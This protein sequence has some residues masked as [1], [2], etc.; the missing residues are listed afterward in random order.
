MRTADLVVLAA[1]FVTMVT[2]GVAYSR[3]KTSDMYFA[4]G[5][6]LSWW[7]GGVSFFMSNV[8]ALSIVVYAGLGFR[9]GLVALTLYGT[10]IPATLL[11]TWLF[12]RRWRR[13][14]VITPTEFLERR[15]SS[16]VRQVLAWSGIPLRVVD[17]ALK[18]VAIGIFVSAGL[19][20]SPN[21]AMLAVGLTIL[22]YSVLGGLW[23]VVVTVFV[24]F[25]LVSGAVV[26]LLPLT[27]RA[28]GG[29]EKFLAA[30]PAGFF[31]PAN[32][33]Y[34]WSYLGAFLVLICISTAGN[35]S[36]VQKFYSAR[37]DRE[38]RGAGWLAA[39]LFLVLPPFWIFTGMLARGFVPLGSLDPQ[40]IYGH[41]A[42][43]LLPAGMLG[44]VVAALFAA[45]MSVLSNG[46]NVLSSVLTVDI[47]QRLIRPRASQRE[48]VLV[49]RLLTGAVGMI[50]LALALTITYFQWTIFDTMV[51]AFGLLVPPT[52]LP[53]LAGLSSRS[54]SARGA[55]AGFAAG[56]A[57]GLA[58]SVYKWVGA[59]AS[60]TSFQA[61]GIVVSTLSTV[62]VLVGAALWFPARGEAAERASQ[63][64]A[65]LE[66][67]S[68]PAEVTVASPA[69][70][71]GL[72]IGI[73]GVVLC[74]IGL[75]V[76]P[77]TSRSVVT[78]IMG[79]VFAAI[80]VA[81]AASLWF[82]RTRTARTTTASAR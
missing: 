69:P 61:L 46:Y 17:E 60:P 30:V 9:Y 68:T 64:F 2:V 43:R 5:R 10:S 32:E 38:A 44:L 49:G 78:L 14:G 58:F 70:I 24:Q 15:F 26:L 47:Y 82:S 35:W 62:L 6:Q 77:S 48:L 81:M 59:P 25:V 54:L 51:A 80:G 72:V 34:G 75:G 29:W 23:A 66:R 4:G 18:I 13:A 50:V 74:V 40:S 57:T 71:A 37:S 73:M 21:V 31:A 8:S 12:A 52:V 53:V 63:F 56:M 41:I 79:V 22:L 11:T 65:A 1:Y 16:L 67:P 20:I 27:L 42:A 39:L 7:L 19:H 45:T 55:L 36:M 33:T 76:L 28:T 3:Q